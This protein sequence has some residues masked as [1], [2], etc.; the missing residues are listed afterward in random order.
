MALALLP[1]H[2]ESFMIRPF[3]L[4]CCLLILVVCT[5]FIGTADA[6]VLAPYDDG[7][8]ESQLGYDDAQ[9]PA[10]PVV[11]DAT[12]KQKTIEDSVM[13]C[14]GSSCDGVTNEWLELTVEPN[15]EVARVAVLYPGSPDPVYAVYSESAAGP[16]TLSFS[17]YG[18]VPPYDVAVTYFDEDGYESAVT[19]V[20][21]TDTVTARRTRS[22]KTGLLALGLVGLVAAVRPRRRTMH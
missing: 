14:G 13:G 18:Y 4:A 11:V 7:P 8:P 17:A 6:C 21:V 10:A 15:A 16:V 3:L 19:V 9:S 22:P 5:V 2:K 20:T 12:M 1:G